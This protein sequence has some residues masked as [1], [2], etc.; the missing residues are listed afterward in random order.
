M[1]TFSPSI[2]KSESNEV[3]K[4][5]PYEKEQKIYSIKKSSK[6]PNKVFDRLFKESFKR[7]M[8]Q[9]IRNDKV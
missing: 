1:C 6:E 8:N 2:I 9:E 3:R 4:V 5:N 7:K